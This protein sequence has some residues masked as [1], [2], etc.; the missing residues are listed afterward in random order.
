M[1]IRPG[2][3]RKAKVPMDLVVGGVGGVMICGS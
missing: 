1:Y 2:C 3:I